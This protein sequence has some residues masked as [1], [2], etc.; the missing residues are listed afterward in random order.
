LCNNRRNFLAESYLVIINC[1]AVA[2]S[3]LL[4]PKLRAESR[5]Q[6]PEVPARQGSYV[7]AHSGTSQETRQPKLSIFLNHNFFYF[8][9]PMGI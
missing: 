8:F 3:S 9:F 5:D 6:N 2:R 7:E 1:G 4:A